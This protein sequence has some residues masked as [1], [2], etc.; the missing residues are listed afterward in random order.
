MIFSATE[1]VA[2][3]TIV[4]ATVV[5][6]VVVGSCS[7]LLIFLAVTGR[8]WK[9]RGSKYLWQGTLLIRMY[10]ERLTPCITGVNDVRV[11]HGKRLY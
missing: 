1:G 11:S 10:L 2:P 7:A 8:L 5:P 3:G 4:A 9:K 6:L